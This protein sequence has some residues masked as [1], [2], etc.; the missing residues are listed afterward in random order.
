[1]TKEYKEEYIKEIE[2]KII[3]LENLNENLNRRLIILENKVKILSKL[4]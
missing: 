4:L 1:M 3:I 2:D